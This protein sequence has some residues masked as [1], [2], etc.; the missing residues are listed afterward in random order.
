LAMN[1]GAL[2]MLLLHLIR[3]TINDHHPRPVSTTELILSLLAIM[4]V[5]LNCIC[6][7]RLIGKST[8]PAA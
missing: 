5:T 1:V 2:T 6:L 8:N 7:F 4:P 3:F